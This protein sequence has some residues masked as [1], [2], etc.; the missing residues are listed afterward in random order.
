MFRAKRLTD[1]VRMS[2]IFPASAS[3]TMLWKPS[4][5]RVDVPL[6]PSSEDASY[7]AL[8]ICAQKPD[9]RHVLCLQSGFSVFPILNWIPEGIQKS[10]GLVG[11]ISHVEKLSEIIPTRLEV[12]TS[13]DGNHIRPR[14]A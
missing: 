6:M 1:F 2:P 14:I 12:V 7:P 9:R 10:H 13:A 3:A 5:L 8:F 4:R 11:I